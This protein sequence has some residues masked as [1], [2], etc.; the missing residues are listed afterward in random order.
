MSAQPWFNCSPWKEEVDDAKAFI[1]LATSDYPDL[2]AAGFR[3][4]L[5]DDAFAAER[6]KMLDDDFARQVVTARAY[7]CKHDI[8]DGDSYS[9][10]HAAE[11][12]GDDNGLAHY[13]SNGA[14]IVAARMLT[15]TLQRK[16][17]S[18]N[19]TFRW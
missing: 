2:S 13:L 15:C 11:K 7:I 19:C 12:W 1:L 3:Q 17:D 6:A 8:G 4:N 5:S 18:P 14:F 9:L 10:K 16:T